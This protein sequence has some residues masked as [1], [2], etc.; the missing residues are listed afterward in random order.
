MCCFT[1]LKYFS[2]CGDKFKP[3]SLPDGIF[4]FWRDLYVH[5]KTKLGQSQNT[6]VSTMKMKNIFNQAALTEANTTTEEMRA[7]NRRKPLIIVPESL[8]CV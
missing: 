4:G 1:I 2:Q 6:K 7:I 8:P 3:F 5:I